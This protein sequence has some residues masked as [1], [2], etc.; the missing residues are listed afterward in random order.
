MKFKKKQKIIDIS[1]VKYDQD[2]IKDFYWPLQTQK[3]EKVIS[4]LSK[5]LI[6][7]I[8][9]NKSDHIEAEALKIFFKWFAV[10][11]VKLLDASIVSQNSRKHRVK[12][13][14]P[15]HYKYLS[16]IVANNSLKCNLFSNK[17]IDDKRLNVFLK[18]FL[19]SILWNYK[20]HKLYFFL[21]G[22]KKIKSFEFSRLIEAHAKKR[23]IFLNPIHF[24]EIFQFENLQSER[25]EL[26]K[27]DEILDIV[28][29]SYKTVNCKLEKNVRNYLTDWI[30]EAVN[31][32]KIIKHNE[33]KILKKF[34]N[35]EEVWFGCGGATIYSAALTS[36]L[37]KNGIK[38]ITHDH[39]SGNAHHGQRQVH[40]T[41][42]MHSDLFIQF[43]HHVAQI[44]K[45]SLKKEFLMGNS[46][47]KLKCL[48]QKNSKKIK[49]NLIS[50]IKTNS[51]FRS[52]MYVST[53]FHAEGQRLRPIIHDMT[54]F[55]WQIR[56]FENMRKHNL[57]IYYKEHPESPTKIPT[58]FFKKHSLI[59]INTKFEDINFEPDIFIIDFIFS[60]TT[61][62]IFRSKKPI[63]FIDLGFPVITK[64]ALSMI[65]KR[66][67][68]LKTN[69][70]ANS[71]ITANW[72]TF[73]SF[74][75]TKE[76]FIDM[77]FTNKYFY[78]C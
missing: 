43:N 19:K 1:K 16:S 59:K 62:S 45:N 69:Y 63:I 76:H 15:K 18:K 60:S 48:F 35:D 25:H 70:E 75:E 51:K 78:N 8:N 50:N 73:D 47:P 20:I 14:I 77:S 53:A 39:G 10:E 36:L 13:I 54:Y 3:S 17:F 72:K 49:Q 23:N 71:R 40:W 11:V 31:F 33:K 22:R 32:L 46:V 24:S 4:Y 37:R 6:S 52:A 28:K 7:F 30:H 42:F 61:P 55:D 26:I 38:I 67:F 12:L 29:K 27:I 9:K 74:F 41:E 5:N 68:Y 34:H 65:K 44:R 66:C 58:N 2:G 57:D 21:F 64:E 56:L